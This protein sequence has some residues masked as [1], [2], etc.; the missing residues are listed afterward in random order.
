MI[1]DGFSY[2]MRGDW[3]GRIIIGGVLAIFSILVL[4]AFI[5]FGYLVAVIRETI[6]G[7]DEPPEFAHWG[8]LLK[9]GFIAIVISFIYSIVPVVVIGG[10]GAVLLGGGSAVGGDGGGLLAGF[11]VLSI[12]LLI[13]IFFLIYY[14]V[15]AAISAYADQNAIG[16]A[17]SLERLKPVLLSSSYLVAVLSP[18]IVGVAIQ[19]ATAV[20]SITVVGLVLVPFLQFYGNV[21]IF[22]M[23]GNAYQKST[24]SHKY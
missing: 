12:L 19:V 18:I 14:I 24:D 1:E 3:V 22:R 5:L 20:L 2:P 15:P 17:F 7:K 23:F 8:E 9:D 11:G 10:I 4:P 16:A 13:P 6:A 21:A